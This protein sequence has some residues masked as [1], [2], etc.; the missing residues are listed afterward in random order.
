MHILAQHW[1][2]CATW[3][4]DIV[5]LF[6]F[7]DIKNLTIVFLNNRKHLK[8]KFTLSLKKNFSKIYPNFFS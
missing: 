7:C 3:I 4:L 2:I 1:F 8:N 6:Q 5:V